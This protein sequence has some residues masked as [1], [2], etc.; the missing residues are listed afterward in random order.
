M[1]RVVH[2]LSWGEREVALVI[3]VRETA[4]VAVIVREKALS[5]AV[6][7]AKELRHTRGRGLRVTGQGSL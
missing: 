3:D 5:T 6:V 7:E 2:G 4:R 1:K